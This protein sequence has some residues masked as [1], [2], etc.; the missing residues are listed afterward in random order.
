MAIASLKNNLLL[1]LKIQAK[2]S[3]SKQNPNQEADSY[4]PNLPKR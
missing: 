4:S 1:L 3:V 2:Y